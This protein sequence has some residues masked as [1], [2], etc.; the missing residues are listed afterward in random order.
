MTQIKVVLYYSANSETEG[1]KGENILMS[2]GLLLSFVWRKTRW[3]KV[4]ILITDKKGP[5]CVFFTFF[6]LAVE[7]R[8]TDGIVSFIS[9]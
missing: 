5:V 1:R 8:E 4:W 3:K 7:S 2:L 9:S 6:F